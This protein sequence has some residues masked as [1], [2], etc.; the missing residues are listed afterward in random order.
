MGMRE[1][2]LD[3][4][5][6]RRF[7]NIF[8]GW[9]TSTVL[10]QA[11]VSYVTR[12]LRQADKNDPAS[13]DKAIKDAFLKLDDDTVQGALES[14]T[15]AG[16]RPRAEIIADIAPAISGSMAVLGIFDPTTATLRVA[17]VGGLPGCPGPPR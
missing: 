13:I 1:C 5:R 11:L 8:R 7:V 14:A 4:N 10:S 12:S 16:S 3:F 9:Q 6:S 15:S 2:S 17:S